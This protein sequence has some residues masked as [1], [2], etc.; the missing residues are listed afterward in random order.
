MAGVH[1]R[2]LIQYYELVDQHFAI[3]RTRMSIDEEIDFL[4]RWREITRDL[5]PIHDRW[6]R[7]GE[8][9]SVAIQYINTI[10]SG[11]RKANAVASVSP[12]LTVRGQ[13]SQPKN[14]FTGPEGAFFL[15]DDKRGPIRREPFLCVR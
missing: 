14:G 15:I 2:A 12:I 6:A 13:S 5:Q 10:S 3:L 1:T 8:S 11:P 4:E 9:V 7:W